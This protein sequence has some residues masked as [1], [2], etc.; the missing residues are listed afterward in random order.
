MRLATAIIQIT[1]DITIYFVL[2]SVATRLD[3]DIYNP[4]LNKVDLTLS[5]KVQVT[6]PH[7]KPYDQSDGR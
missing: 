5:Y 7:R 2:Q 3:N 1:F 4:G 6:D